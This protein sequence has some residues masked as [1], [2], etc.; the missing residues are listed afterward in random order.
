MSEE[1]IL[2]QRASERDPV[3]ITPRSKHQALLLIE[4]NLEIIFGEFPAYV[5]AF[6]SMLNNTVRIQKFRLSVRTRGDGNINITFDELEGSPEEVKL[7][8]LIRDSTVEFCELVGGGFYKITDFS[9]P[10]TINMSNMARYNRKQLHLEIT[11]V[12]FDLLIELL[13][14][15][16][17]ANV[18]LE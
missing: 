17:F 10:L 9:S 13:L 5:K 7:Q 8:I 15:D 18:P 4:K 14:S 16:I 1:T 3:N 6:V 12:G 2:S 11:A